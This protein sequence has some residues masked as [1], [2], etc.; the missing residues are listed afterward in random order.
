MVRGPTVARRLTFAFPGDLDT[1]TGGYIY[2]KRIIAELT[3]QGWQVQAL[4]LDE[5][6]PVVSVTV[7]TQTCMRLAQVD[8]ASQLVIDGLALGAMGEDAR[9]IAQSRP[10]TALVHHPL[11]LES[12]L[13]A[14]TASMLQQ[15][16]QTALGYAQGVIVTSAITKQTLVDHF[17]VM[18]DRITVVLPGVDRPSGQLPPNLESS[19]KRP[20]SN[21]VGLLSVGAIVP[22]K[23]FDVLIAALIQLKHLDWRLT[24]VGD[25]QRAPNTTQQIRQTI[26]EHNLQDRICLT[27]AQAA[28]ELAVHYRQADVFVLASRYEGYGMAYSEALAWGLPVIGTDAGAARDTLATAAAK[29]VPAD[30]IE[31]LTHAL[32]QLMVD[33]TLR[34]NMRKAA[35]SHAQT[36]PSWA[37]SGTRFA[38]TL[39]EMNTQSTARHP[40]HKTLP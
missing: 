36:L 34:T 2:D 21:T 27:G 25:D 26:K 29:T 7:R 10:F 16:E 8:L 18:P 24:I 33:T 11:A 28:S 38:Q 30:N 1:L 5:R 9:L 3:A 6:F 32:E 14:D 12:G 19:A 23:G 15:S 4:S 22:R 13:D 17:G 20:S 39:I 40:D 35:L 37:N 31:A